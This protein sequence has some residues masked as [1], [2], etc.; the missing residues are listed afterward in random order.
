MGAQSTARKRRK[1]AQ[2]QR[3]GSDGVERRGVG[4]G[5]ARAEARFAWA[6]MAGRHRVPKLAP[7]PRPQVSA[8]RVI[9]GRVFLVRWRF[10]PLPTSQIA[11]SAMGEV[12]GLGSAGLALQFVAG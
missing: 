3:E 7:R 4:G 9:R 11:P 8:I 6:M 10:D 12:C 1:G 5:C 2:R